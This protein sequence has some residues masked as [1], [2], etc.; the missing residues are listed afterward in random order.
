VIAPFG[1]FACWKALAKILRQGILL[2]NDN[3]M[4]PACSEAFPL[5]GKSCYVSEQ[6]M[7]ILISKFWWGFV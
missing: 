3:V 5:S 2:N 6:T 7:L 1:L 4:V